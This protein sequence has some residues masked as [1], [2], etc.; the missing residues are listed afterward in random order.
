MSQLP[1]ESVAPPKRK[2]SLTGGKNPFLVPFIL[3]TALFF[4]WGVVHSLDSIL[5]PHL[6]K[7]C[8]LNNR[9]SALV[10]T[11]VY[12]AYFLMA[13]PAGMFLKRWGYKTGIIFGLLVAASG[14][15][16]FVPAANARSFELFLLA[17]FIIGCGI[18]T[19][20]TAA[21]PYSALL[22]PPE[23]S[24]VRMNLAASFNGLASFVAP[25][26]GTRFILSGV[27]HG[28]AELAA[29]PM[30][31]KLSYLNSEAASVKLPY[32][33]F[34]G[35]LIL[36]AVLFLFFHFPEVRSETKAVRLSQFVKAFRHRH[37]TWAV[38]AQFAYVGAQVCVTSFF[39][40]MAKQGGGLD[41]KT[42]G[43]YLS[44]YGLLF[45][46]GRF[47]GTF[48]LRF[49]ARHKL[50]T[51]YAVL[52]TLLCLPAILG[53]GEYV[54]YAL[55]GIGFFMS[56]MFPTIFSLGLVELG[57]D[58]KTGGSLLVMSIIGGALFPYIMAWVIDWN[59]DKIQPGYI[60]P[61]IC[62][63]VI[64]Y[65]GVKGYKVKIHEKAVELV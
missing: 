53:K 46:A 1:V 20:E 19:L 10:D 65:F 8:E 37:L 22:G 25:L 63:L 6:K 24:G 57:E 42:A 29:M 51:I 27:E 39:I 14:A 11:A 30:A 13:I 48:L 50:L 49:V 5:I 59:G 58:T 3:I 40:R 45:M 54:V 52:C 62:Y 31:Q 26:V 15:L 36:V 55:G 43:Y 23:S 60:V 35:L 18:A 9:Q 33:V 4:L 61:M 34:A 38:I 47:V 44:I 16:L 17:L 7:A 32:L 28:K 2:E 41:E 56:I 12:V 21:N 64:I